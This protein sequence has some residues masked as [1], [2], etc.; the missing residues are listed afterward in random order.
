MEPR[1]TGY[2]IRD[3]DT[4]GGE[5]TPETPHHSIMGSGGPAVKYIEYL[6]H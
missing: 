3:R 1:G 4:S 5:K 2:E 6:I